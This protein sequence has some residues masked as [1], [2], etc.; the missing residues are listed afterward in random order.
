MQLK[1]DL[2]PFLMMKEN[3]KK[4]KTLKIRCDSKA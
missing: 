4:K 3:P 1:V 2:N